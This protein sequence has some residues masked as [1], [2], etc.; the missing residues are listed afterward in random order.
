MLKSKYSSILRILFILIL[1]QLSLF[2]ITNQELQQLELKIKQIQKAEEFRLNR[3]L[4]NIIPKTTKLKSDIEQDIKK[5][6]KKSKYCW[7]L[8]HIKLENITKL[9]KIEQL[10]ITNN[11]INRCV[12]LNEIDELINDIIVI[13]KNKGYI[14]SRVYIKPNQNLKSDTLELLVLEGK[15]SD[16]VFSDNENNKSVNLDN[17]F[18]SMIDNYLNLRDIEQGMEQINRLQS[19]SSI[20]QIRPSSKIGNSTIAIYNDKLK[21]LS[22]TINIDNL[23]SESTGRNQ[24][25]VSFSLDNP[26][27]YNDNIGTTYRRTIPFNSTNK[28]ESASLNYNIPYGYYT[29][30]LGSS[31]SK[32]FSKIDLDSNNSIDSTGKTINSFISG[33]K[34]IY[35]DENS[36]INTGINLTFKSTKNYID[37]I[38]LTT[39]SNNLSVLD[40]NLN[41]FLLI[42]NSST[43]NANISY[44]QGL[45]SFGA[46]KDTNT[47]LKSKFKRY[48]L[49]LSYMK[50]LELFGLPASFSNNLSFQQSDDSLY[51]SEQM[52]IGGFYS[53]R[54]FEGVSVSG[55]KGVVLNNDFSIIKNIYDIDTTFF[56]A[57]DY[58]RIY[59]NY[60]I[61]GAELSGAAY[62]LKFLYNDLFFEVTKVFDISHSSNID[63]NSNKGNYTY[64]NLIY[65]F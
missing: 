59:S 46:T 22:S 57:Y 4:Y 34:V 38:F 41:Y 30:F 55:N 58:G 8:K 36:K 47:T 48:N 19:N 39:S 37:D 20:M 3:D 65:S 29:F 62:G 10:N 13:Y 24:I 49:S 18:P 63:I 61:I 15:V 56:I 26:F 33:D 14:S 54:G 17:I 32:Y 45:D 35:R 52:S 43:I 64:L 50:G 21:K 16:I 25:G 51:G 31:I 12:P 28:N 40:F 23:G 1:F 6:K 44:S 42:D 7:N 11:Y 53:V 9:T 60:D 27:N 2:S 5:D